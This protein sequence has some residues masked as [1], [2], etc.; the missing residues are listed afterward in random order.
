MAAIAEVPVLLADRLTVPVGAWPL[1]GPASL[2]LT[3][4]KALKPPRWCGV[5]GAALLAKIEI[6]RVDRC[7]CDKFTIR[8]YV[9]MAI[10]RD[11]FDHE[12]WHPSTLLGRGPVQRW[13]VVAGRLLGRP[14][15]GRPVGGSGLRICP[16]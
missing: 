5:G 7:R 6:Y 9:D 4:L 13:L 14:A 16:R 10:W 12:A 15:S 11:A 2:L 3:L 1:S 8:R